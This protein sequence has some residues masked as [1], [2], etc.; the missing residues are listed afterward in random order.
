MTLTDLLLQAVLA[1][2]VTIG[3]GV[4]FNVLPRALIPCGLVGV[5]G[6]LARFSLRQL[7]VSNEVSTFLGALVVGLF[8]YWVSRR[9]RM[10]R[11]V[12]T[13]TGIITM[14]PGIS[15]YET[16]I[17]FS[18]GNILDGLQSAVRAGLAT[19]AIAIGLST[20]RI[21]TEFE[22]SFYS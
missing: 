4:L 14:I 6:H 10:P 18:R 22:L 9:L 17:F 1:L 13:V 16:I 7:G 21:L 11:L 12:F 2:C 20:A 15:A 8:G 19:A 5:L 3:F